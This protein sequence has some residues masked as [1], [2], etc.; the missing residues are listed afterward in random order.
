MGF[1]PLL[2]FVDRWIDGM[3]SFEYW[4]HRYLEAVGFEGCHFKTIGWVWKR[5]R[6]EQRDPNA[7]HW[8]GDE[9]RHA[10]LSSASWALRAALRCVSLLK[11][12]APIQ[13]WRGRAKER[14]G[15][16]YSLEIFPIHPHSMGSQ[17]EFPNHLIGS[18]LPVVICCFLR[19]VTCFFG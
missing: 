8:I 19:V 10:G 5:A 18:V 15:Y 13:W 14:L 7:A 12:I 16:S 17:R 11:T 9:L 3:N 1:C 2:G 6:P 4:I